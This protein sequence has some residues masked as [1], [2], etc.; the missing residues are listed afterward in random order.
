MIHIHR[1]GNTRELGKGY[2]LFAHNHN[3]FLLDQLAIRCTV[4]WCI[5]IDVFPFQIITPPEANNFMS[6]MNYRRYFSV[7]NL[8]NKKVDKN[9]VFTNST[10]SFSNIKTMIFI[11]LIHLSISLTNF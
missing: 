4:Y 6:D 1:L 10:Y 3:V 7:P 5:Y 2:S 11:I 8:L 9:C